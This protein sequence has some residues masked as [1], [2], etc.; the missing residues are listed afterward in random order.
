MKICYTCKLKKPFNDFAKKRRNKD[1]LQSECKLCCRA[2]RKQWY[3]NNI[4]LHKTNVAK[5]KKKAREDLK[6]FIDDLKSTSSCS[7]CGFS[8]PATLQFHHVRDKIMEISNMIFKPYSKKKVIEE[9][10]KCI[11]L[12][13]NCH[14]IHHYNEKQNMPR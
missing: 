12:C 8:H 3:H 1:G 11:I 14:A 7:K 10:K 13:A 2:Y 6:K 4:V 5:R 9:I